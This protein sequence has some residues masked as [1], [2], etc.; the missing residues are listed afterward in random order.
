MKEQEIE[1]IEDIIRYWRYTAQIDSS[2]AKMIYDAGYRNV[3]EIRDILLSDNSMGKK[4]I[5]IT[6]YVAPNADKGGS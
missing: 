2:L 6:E 5:M 4:L 3:N 1:K